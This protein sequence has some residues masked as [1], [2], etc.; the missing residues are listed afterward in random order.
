MEEGQAKKVLRFSNVLDR[1]VES[2]VRIPG[3]SRQVRDFAQIRRSDDYRI[4]LMV[5]WVTVL[6][7][8][9]DFALAS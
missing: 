2:I 4:M 9:T 1:A 8:V 3:R 5:S 7:V 6:N